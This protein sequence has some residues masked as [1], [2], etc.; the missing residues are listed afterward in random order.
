MDEITYENLFQSLRNEGPLKPSTS[1]SRSFILKTIKQKYGHINWEQEYEENIKSIILNFSLSL[2]KKWGKCNRNYKLFINQ[3]AEWLKTPFKLPP[4]SPKKDTSIKRGYVGRPKKSFSESSK[5]SKRR[6][7]QEL[8]KS[9]SA[10]ELVYAAKIKLQKSGR[11]CA[12]EL[13]ND[14]LKNPSK[15]YEIR[16]SLQDME[17]TKKQASYTTDEALC[18]LLDND[19]TKQQ[20]INIR[21]SAQNRNCT[22]YPPYSE[23]INSKKRCYPDDLNITESTCQVPL[24]NLLNHTATRIIESLNS[25]TIATGMENVE[26]LC[27]WGCDGSSGHAQYKQKFDQSSSITVTDTDLFLFSLVPLQIRCAVNNNNIV[28]WQNPKPS[29]TRF[30]RPIKYCNK[31]ETIASTMEEV[32]AIDLEI[33]S[34]IPTTVLYEGQELQINHKLIFSMVDGKVSKIVSNSKK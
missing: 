11:R 15:A 28:L 23:I 10:A 21:T 25:Q 31:K 3:N 5:A 32:N 1:K 18:F 17:N 24:Q 34:L 13:L 14:I 19:L 16:K 7:I 9:Y 27:K 2:G 29:S 33:R 22:I 4:Q 6:K 20:Y 26:M 8:T 30:C 12:A